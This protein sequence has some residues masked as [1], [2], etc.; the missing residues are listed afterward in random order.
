[1]ADPSLSEQVI[2]TDRACPRCGYNVRGL[3]YTARCPECGTPAIAALTGASLP[4]LD[5]PWIEKLRWASVCALGST[6][7]I[8]VGSFLGCVGTRLVGDGIPIQAAIL[9]SAALWLLSSWFAT[10]AY[11]G[12]QA[13][14]FERARLAARTAQR[15]LRQVIVAAVVV[16]LLWFAA[17][18]LG[19]VGWLPGAVFIVALL[20][21][22]FATFR[23]IF[24]P[25]SLH[26]RLRKARRR[27]ELIQS[28]NVDES[29]PEF[30]EF[31][32]FD[33]SSVPA[34][35]SPLRTPDSERT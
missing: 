9:I 23:A 8:T 15:I 27:I 20:V 21:V 19:L 26:A 11:P 18:L 5:L 4:Q 35:E 31:R 29:S 32:E 2:R 24:L 1:M 30:E 3:S 17:A 16:C 13:R 25:A 33:P 22:A 7:M 14:S 6:M 28:G 10:A 12:C 34:D